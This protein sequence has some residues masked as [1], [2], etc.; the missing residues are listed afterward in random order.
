MKE[1]GSEHF[2]KTTWES[3]ASGEVQGLRLLLVLFWG[4]APGAKMLKKSGWLLNPNR[5]QGSRMQ[6]AIV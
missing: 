2:A 1:E 3:N 5:L 4:I 6:Q